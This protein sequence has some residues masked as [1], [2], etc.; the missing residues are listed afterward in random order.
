MTAKKTTDAPAP[1]RNGYKNAYLHIPFD[2]LAD[3]CSVLIRN[4]RLL[5]GDK[6]QA[7]RAVSDSDDPGVQQDAMNEVLADVIVAWRKMYAANDETPD[8]DL[9]GDEDLEALMARLE[10]A[11]QEPL[12]AVTRA[13][14]ARLPVVVTNRISEEFKKIADPK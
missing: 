9:D 6:L 8:I 5:P 2:E 13:N 7:L 10:A 12:G 3:G 14:V 11:E 4:P 1:A